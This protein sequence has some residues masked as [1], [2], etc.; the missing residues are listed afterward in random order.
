MHQGSGFEPL[1]FHEPSN[2][3]NWAVA[4]QCLVLLLWI[5]AIVFGFVMIARFVRAHERL[6]E[7]AS[8]IAQKLGDR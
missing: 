1:Q 7:S 8:Q 5:W 4:L 2:F 3:F 6:A